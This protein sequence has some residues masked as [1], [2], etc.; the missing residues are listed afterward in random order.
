MK[1][2]VSNH[3]EELAS[4]L[5]EE[6]FQG[7]GHPFDKRWIVVPNERVKQDLYLQWAHDPL[8]EVAAGCKMITWSEALSRL[9]PALPSQAELSLKIE[10]ALKSVQDASLLAYLEQ[11]SLPRKASLCDR[12]ST[13]F[14]HYLN[15]P[16]EKLLLWL[17][18]EGWQQSLWRA[19]FGN[20]IPW[21]TSHLLEGSVYL[22]HPFQVAPYQLAAFKQMEATC[23]LFSPCAMY[24]G[25]FHTFKEQG[26]LL[27]RVLPRNRNE[28][29]QFFENE[30]M[31]LANWG[32]KGRQLLSFFEDEEWIDAYQEP[33]ADTLLKKIQQEMLTLSLEEKIPDASIQ[34][35]SAPSKLREVEVVWEIIQRLPFKPSEILVLAPDM[36]S[37]AGV[38]ELVFRQRGGPFDFA[39][40]GLEARS[41]SPLMQGLE[42]LLELP[43]Y[44]FSKESVEKLLFC[45]AF[46]KKFE[47]SIEDA[48]LLLKWIS[49]VHIRYD[50]S[51][52]PG[53]W[54]EGLKRLVH[55]L[56]ASVRENQLTI[57][58]SD[59]DVLSRWITVTQL[60]QAISQKERS[61][62][63]WS[64]HLKFL[65]DQFFALDSDDP[66]L[67]ELENLQQM[68]IEGEFPFSTIERILKKIFQQT[69]GAVQGSHLQAVRFTSL[70]KGALIP[71]KV[72]IL[73]GME[74]GSFPRQDPP[75][76]LQQLLVPSRIE[77]DKYLFLEA[78]CSAREM[79]IMTY[80]RIH[81]EDGKSQKP[82]PLVEE[83][84]H[85][86]NLSITDHP[87]SPFDPT[88][89]QQEGFRSYSRAHFDALQ[90]ITAEPPKVPIL[91]AIHSNFDIGMLRRLARHPLKFFFE[92]RVGIDFEW[93]EQSTE[94][95]ISPL[96]MIRLRKASLTKP[97]EVLIQEMEKEGRL[98][99]GSFSKAAVQ[100]IQSEIETYHAMLNK[101][102]VR[103]E[104]IYSIE[105]KTSCKQPTQI[106]EKTWIYPALQI[107]QGM[108]QGRIDEL[109][110]QGLLFHGEDNLADQLKAWPL[111]LICDRLGITSQLLFTK[112]GKISEIKPSSDSLEKYL[113]YAQKALTMPS[114]LYPKWVRGLFKDGK[115]PS[116]EEDE[117]ITW[118]QKRDLLPPPDVWLKAW[119]PDLQEVVNELL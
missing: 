59:A 30:H 14:L 38:V 81:P 109:S 72:V 103:P 35:H 54:E 65:V 51:N 105:L 94:F 16:E 13:L 87:F 32:R 91:P 111:L 80:L 61:L 69:S 10:A 26:Y 56:V 57:D 113:L 101:L 89:Y 112:K 50:L 98:P 40:F 64:K 20:T 48:H 99:V 46:L 108:I 117:V 76:S 115:I 2:F 68:D 43:H 42:A 82:S 106:D 34:I 118:A 63:E 75:S 93:K 83:L 11:G 24:W 8:L 70:E 88:Y 107:S 90:K 102:Q 45:P 62:K 73:M 74:E 84:T 53:S 15:Q 36:Q 95:V 110:P 85:Y 86:G 78:F 9:F 27:K 5:K 114:P 55:A 23:F 4:C 22:F 28:L 18:K 21:K 19:V 25:D 29:L 100:K 104:E 71:A 119:S 79:L 17:E 67:R 33:I 1:I 52:D 7:M 77:E 12:M 92:E 3:L 60:F 47:F 31:L 116:E 97:L 44:R 49:Q 66:L 39:I 96:D 6:L 41:K 58:F 37:Y